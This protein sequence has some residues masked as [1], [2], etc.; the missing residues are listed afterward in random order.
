M[1]N[2]NEQLGNSHVYREDKQCFRVS[3]S[4]QDKFSQKIPNSRDVNCCVLCSMNEGE[5]I[6]PANR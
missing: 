1:V 2:K 5:F 6:V 4:E 3:V